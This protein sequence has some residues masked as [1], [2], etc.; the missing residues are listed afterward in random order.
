MVGITMACAGFPPSVSKGRPDAA[1]A[2]AT[3]RCYVVRAIFLV[4]SRGHVQHRKILRRGG[5]GDWLENSEG[6]RK[7]GKQFF[8]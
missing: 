7:E 1:H 5:L 8:F 3:P 6:K 4:A 2:S